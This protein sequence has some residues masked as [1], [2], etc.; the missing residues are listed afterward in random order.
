MVLPTITFRSRE[1]AAISVIKC[2]AG[3][4]TLRVCSIC[5]VSPFPFCRFATANSTCPTVS[6]II[7]I[8]H[9]I[10]WVAGVGFLIRGQNDAAVVLDLLNSTGVEGGRQICCPCPHSGCRSVVAVALLTDIYTVHPV[11]SGGQE[12][13]G[14]TTSF[15]VEYFDNQKQ[16]TRGRCGTVNV[17]AAR[18]GVALFAERYCFSKKLKNMSIYVEFCVSR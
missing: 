15:V 4:M 16:A 2:D 14:T 8:F 6:T 9:Q 5:G 17:L 1:T 10:V 11:M 12:V 18:H 13:P 7:S 3:A